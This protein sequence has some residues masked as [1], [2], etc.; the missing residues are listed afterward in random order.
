MDSEEI[1]NIIEEEVTTMCNKLKERGIPGDAFEV[2]ITVKKAQM[3]PRNQEG[4]IYITKDIN[5]FIRQ[6]KESFGKE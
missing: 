5:E 2:R 3:E 4:Q 6:M 1:N